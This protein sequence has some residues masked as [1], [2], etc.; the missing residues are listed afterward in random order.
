MGKHFDAV[1]KDLKRIGA[2][3]RINDLNEGI[4]VKFQSNDW[5]LLDD[6][7]EAVIR[8]ELRELGY[9]IKGDK[10]APRTAV[11]EAWVTLANQ[12]R[13]NPIKAYFEQLRQQSYTPVT[14]GGIA[15]VPCAIDLLKVYL[16]NPDKWAT[17]WLFRWMVGA[18]AR[19]FRQER[20]PMFVMAGEQEKG[21]STFAR[22]L[23][24]PALQE[25]YREGAIRPDSKDERLALTDIFLQEVPELGS[26]TRRADIEGLKDHITRKYIV[27]RPPYGSKPI[28]KPAVTNFIGSVNPDGAG[29]LADTT[30]N[31]R[32]LVTEINGF[33]F[34]YAQMNVN[35]L[36]REALWFYDNMPRSWELT[37]EERK[38]RDA[39]NAQF[40]MVNALEDVILE[41]LQLTGNNQ[42][43]VPTI[44]IR[45]HL[46]PHYRYTT[47]QQFN[48][49]L[50][51]TLKQM[52]LQAGRAPYREGG[53]HHRGWFGVKLAILSPESA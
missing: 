32:F 8:T 36:W 5:R 2:D 14:D 30:G 41:H 49:D 29:F 6:T 28:K 20:N 10:K 3:F 7:T 21:K 15:P 53:A 17:R 42:D 33:D 40:E 16:D 9:G 52:G 22:W 38:A 46:A 51:K 45:Q 27:E 23:C 12:Q 25:F 26:T 43:F 1:V 19:V 39:I 35:T 50:S 34:A 24:P 47:E 4:E 48:R 11:T 18:I 13:Y 37:P 44:K 31:S